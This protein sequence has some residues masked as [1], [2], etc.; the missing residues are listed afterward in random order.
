[1]ST[2]QHAAAG[3]DHTFNAQKVFLGLFAF[4]AIEVG[5]GYAGHYLH[6]GKLLLWG[7]LIV[8]ALCKGFLI[9]SYF[10]HLR[11][12]GWIVKGLIAPTPVLVVVILAALTPDVGAPDESKLVNKIGSMYDPATGMV[13]DLGHGPGGHGAPAEGASGT[14]PGH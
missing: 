8:W 6:W 12:E 14:A 2:E 3:H 7:G 11:F 4:T 1:M 5:W 9:A 13:R 10:M